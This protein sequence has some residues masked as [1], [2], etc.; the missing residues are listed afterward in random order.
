MF[1]FKDLAEGINALSVYFTFAIC[2]GVFSI[3]ALIYNVSFIGY[4][5]ISFLYFYI[6]F[7]LNMNFRSLVKED[8]EG[9]KAFQLILQVILLALWIIS[10][11]KF[12]NSHS[13]IR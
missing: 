7:F 9:K 6:A 12:Y 1:S 3:F 8:T 11:L 13:A 5:F 4:G 10:L 2:S